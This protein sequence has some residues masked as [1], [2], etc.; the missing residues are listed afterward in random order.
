MRMTNETDYALRIMRRLASGDENIIDAKTMSEEIAVPPRFTL[1]ILRKL[2]SGGLVRSYKGASG[3][4]TLARRPE[5]ITMRQIIETI[6]GPLTITRCLSDDYECSRSH[7]DGEKSMCYF[8][9]VFDSINRRIAAELE[10][11]TLA[12]AVA[13]ECT[14][15][16]DEKQK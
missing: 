5:E 8:H 6:D 12:M 14:A 16:T 10:Q 13:D 11:I 15:K 3:G 4:Y 2:M 1:K 7:G 9:R